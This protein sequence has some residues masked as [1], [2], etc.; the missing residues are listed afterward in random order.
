M[1]E[2]QSRRLELGREYARRIEDLLKSEPTSNSTYKLLDA[3][4]GVVRDIQEAFSSGK[5]HASVVMP[6]GSGKTLI[7]AKVA[8]ALGLRTL[9]ISPSQIGVEQVE[10]TFED[11]AEEDPS[12]KGRLGTVYAGHKEFRKQFTVTTYRSFTDYSPQDGSRSL[13]EGTDES[14]R[15]MF[16]PDDYDLVILDEAHLSL[17]E[18]RREVASTFQNCARLAFTATPVFNEERQ[19]E[20]AFG[21]IISRLG[22]KEAMESGLIA[23]KISSHVVKT[24][25]DLTSLRPTQLGRYEPRELARRINTPERN[26]AAV[27][28]YMQHFL[29]EQIIVKCA[30][31]KHANTMESLFRERLVEENRRREALRRRGIDIPIITVTHVASD[32][33]GSDVRRELG[34]AKRGETTIVC[35]ASLFDVA[36]DAPSIRL[37]MNLVPNLV[38]AEVEQFGGRIIRKDRKTGQHKH[39]INIDFVDIDNTPGR[40][41]VIY[42]QILGTPTLT[43]SFYQEPTITQREVGIGAKP[44]PNGYE[45]INDPARMRLLMRELYGQAVT[46]NVPTPVRFADIR[47]ALRERQRVIAL[48]RSSS[49]ERSRVSFGQL[50]DFQRF[51]LATLEQLRSSFAEWEATIRSEFVSLPQDRLEQTYRKGLLQVVLQHAYV[52]SD[53][54]A[55]QRAEIFSKDYMIGLIQTYTNDFVEILRA[56][57]NMDMT[58]RQI[59]DITGVSSVR[60]GREIIRVMREFQAQ[61][62]SSELMRLAIVH[63]PASVV[64][65]LQ[66]V[67]ELQR[68]YPTLT[69]WEFTRAI[70]SVGFDRAEEALSNKER[71]LQMLQAAYPHIPLNAIKKALEHFYTPEPVLDVYP[72]PEEM[73]RIKQIYNLNGE[74]YA[75]YVYV[76]AFAG[77]RDGRAFLEAIPGQIE[78]LRQFEE[79]VIVGGQTTLQRPFAQFSDRLIVAAIENNPGNPTHYLRRY[80]ETKSKMLSQSPTRIA[81]EEVLRI[82]QRDRELR[83]QSI[84]DNIINEVWDRFKELGKFE[85]LD[86]TQVARAVTGAFEWLRKG[87]LKLLTSVRYEGPGRRFVYSLTPAATQEVIRVVL[88][89]GS[90]PRPQPSSTEEDDEET[91]LVTDVQTVE[92]GVENEEVASEVDE[93]LPSDEV[94]D[95]LHE[96]SRSNTNLSDQVDRLAEFLEEVSDVKEVSGKGE[97]YSL[98]YTT[99]SGVDLLVTWTRG[100]VSDNEFNS[101][102][103]IT[104]SIKTRIGALRH[105]VTFYSPS[106][107]T[108]DIEENVTKQLIFSDYRTLN[109]ALRDAIFG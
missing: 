69:P 76:E 86:R 58:A 55:E 53:L 87:E 20:E 31:I 93:A 21:E 23:E 98:E 66:R 16:Y 47:S 60:H 84:S 73:A 15:N 103:K 10:E 54:S 72:R 95:L 2:F 24:N 26:N 96:I 4:I 12:W 38:P 56:C 57:M 109:N 104:F 27:D 48:E 80:L 30:D 40:A 17:S 83:V 102:T 88:E 107:E 62:V 106:S 67:V 71:R 78:A 39:A 75:N 99:Y 89:T 90:K 77:H 11:L 50:N 9:I 8:Q 7:Y 65:T 63:H 37:A 70:N 59:L 43:A 79:E 41:P 101:E 74:P 14:T 82:L 33:T 28:V 68:I 94:L 92:P 91:T 46:E 32:M 64:P 45:Y 25:V 36:F 44:L 29:G 22:I 100:R 42:G 18:K 6:T 19:V 1:G 34:K 105:I 13:P 85:E 49:I 81:R 3:Q 35:A 51:A 5:M 61:N 52:F 97:T 108:T